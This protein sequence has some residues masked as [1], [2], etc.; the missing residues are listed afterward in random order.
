M[1]LAN[2]HTA[3]DRAVAL[4]DE[5]DLRRRRRRI[6]SRAPTFATSSTRSAGIVVENS[7]A[8][9]NS[10]STTSLAIGT[11]SKSLTVDTGKLYAVGQFVIARR[12]HRARRTT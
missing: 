10:T 1:S 9:Y 4:D 7:A 11:G 5:R 12:A 6:S 3:A 2:R 8:N